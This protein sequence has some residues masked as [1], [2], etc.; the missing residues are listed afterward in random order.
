MLTEVKKP[1]EVFYMPQRLLVPLF[2]R[3]YVWSKEGQ[4]EPLWNDVLRVAE[5]ILNKQ[6]TEAHFLG[7]VVLQQQPADIG[8][9]PVRTVIDGQQRLTTLQLLLDAVHE[10]VGVAGFEAI[11]KQVQDLVENAEHF[12]KDPEDRYKVWPTNRDREA[13]NEVMSASAPIDYES[14]VNSKSK[15][16]QCHRYFAQQAHE[17]LHLDELVAERANALVQTVSVYLQLVVIELLPNEDA[18]E[19]FETLNAR[20]T[21]LTAADLIKNLIFQKLDVSPGQA[22]KAYHEHWEA[23]ETPFWEMEVSSGRIKYSR[24]SLFLTHW[25]ISKTALDIPAREIFSQFKRYVNEYDG[26]IFGLLKEISRSAKSYRALIEIAEDSH[27]ELNAIQLFVYRTASMDSDVSKPL[28]IWLLDESLPEIPSE[29]VLK[30]LQVIESWMVRR[31]VI[32]LITKGYNR[33]FISLLQE[34]KSSERSVC[35]D[36]TEEFFSKKTAESDYWPGDSEVRESLLSLEIYRKMSKPR[37]RMFLEAIEDHRRG[38]NTPRPLHEQR[39]VRGKCSIE[40]VMPQE[41]E[42]NWN[43]ALS[44]AQIRDRDSNIQRIGN[45]TLLTQALNSKVSNGPW[46]GD[47]GKQQ[48]LMD[49]TSLLITQEV[50]KNETWNEQ[51]ISMRTEQMA[52]DIVEIWPVPEGHIG[53]RSNV[54]VNA[55]ASANV[56]DLVHAGMLEPGQ[57]LYSRRQIHAG[58]H[59]SVGS[60]GRIYLGEQVFMTPSGAA[61]ALSGSVSEAGWWFWLVE[62]D[63][64]R[65]LSDIRREYLEGFNES[66]ELADID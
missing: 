39:V 30:T 15:M 3:P 62:A 66:Q 24:S 29:Q 61:K 1:R 57:L 4:W 18:Q 9:L 64:E 38:F 46:L 59:A 22:E 14:L 41:W 48:A 19:I 49:H 47:K 33:L 40:H 5:K 56:A 55:G 6:E 43:Q 17:W 10:E 35:G 7:A 51:L 12:V 54:T 31:S 28:L 13:F 36:T 23:F 21:P 32:R 8:A 16:V 27:A 26:D 20:G 25:L 2:Q 34:L 50:T 45:L 44:E 58:R 52:E 42:K 63:G 37:L 65:S 11:A 60:D 53:T